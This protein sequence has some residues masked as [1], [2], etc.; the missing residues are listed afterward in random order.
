MPFLLLF[1]SLRIIIS[2]N[3]NAF[4]CQHAF[5]LSF[6]S[7]V[8]LQISYLLSLF[9][10]FLTCISSFGAISMKAFYI[11]LLKIEIKYNQNVCNWNN[12]KADKIGR[13]IIF[14]QIKLEYRVAMEKQPLESNF[15]FSFLLT[16]FQS[17][18][19]LLVFGCFFLL[20]LLSVQSASRFWKL[21]YIRI[22]SFRASLASLWSDRFFLS[23][24]AL[25]FQVFSVSLLSFLCCCKRYYFF[26]LSHQRTVIYALSVCLSRLRTFIKIS[27]INIRNTA[28]NK[29][30]L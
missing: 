26:D 20:S 13:W 2:P 24:F 25:V 27:T 23:L 29:N 16:D 6:F 1:V 10:W 30:I 7:F 5:F 17:F 21:C 11:F 12:T 22:H 8:L 4:F 19:Y 18:L 14:R 15:K 9:P 28:Y 3:L